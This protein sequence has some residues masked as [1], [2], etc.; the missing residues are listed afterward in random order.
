VSKRPILIGEHFSPWTEKAR[1]ALDHHGVEHDYRE[2]VPLLGEPLLRLRA[3]K[4]TGRV[5]VPILLT[6]AGP[7][8]DSLQIAEH[9]ERMGRSEPLF[10]AAQRAEIL[11]WNQK[12]ERAIAAARISY[13]ERVAASR[14]AK[15]EMQPA[16]MP[17]VIR[18]ASVP[19]T[20]LAIAFL[21][22]KYGVDRAATEQAEATWARELDGL[23]AALAG[24]PHLLDA[25]SYADITMALALQF[26]SPVAND[27]LPLGPATRASC[28]HATLAERYS[29]LIAWRDAL[30]ERHRRRATS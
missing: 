8:P 16:F 11:D 13:L 1:W 4:L 23:R 18:R 24:R 19:A 29:D 20:D 3:R 7:I 28:L 6:D 21:R 14:E 26:L 25:F 17:A 15:I 10:P 9:A 22:R 27:Q 2:H 12:S 5:S 30:Y